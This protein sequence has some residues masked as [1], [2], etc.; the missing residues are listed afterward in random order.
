[1]TEIIKGKVL[2]IVTQTVQSEGKDGQIKEKEKKVITIY[3]M[4]E[5]DGKK[6][7]YEASPEELEEYDY[8]DDVV[9]RIE[10]PQQTLPI[11]TPIRRPIVDVD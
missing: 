4:G 10:K 9:I 7:V 11:A 2:R 3:G 6:F 8:D 1:M 5:S